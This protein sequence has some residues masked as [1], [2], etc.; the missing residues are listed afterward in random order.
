MVPFREYPNGLFLRKSFSIIKVTALEVLSEPLTLLVLLAALVLT[1]LAPAFHYHQ[2]GDPSRMARDAGFSALLMGGSVLAVFGT[3]RTFRRE[4]E[5]GTLEGALSHPISRTTFFLSKTAGIFLA[6]LIFA[7]LVFGTTS[8]IVEGAIIGG[9]LAKKTGMLARI[10]GPCLLGGVAVIILPLVLSAILNR[11]LH[12]RFVVSSL[13]LS[14]FFSLINFGGALWLSKGSIIRLFPV[15]ILVLL[16]TVIL[17]VG[18]AVF[19]IRLKANLAAS[20]AGI[21]FLVLIPAI[22]NYYLVDA[23][24]DGGV[25]PYSYVGLA[26]LVTLPAVIAFLLLGIHLITKQDI[27]WTR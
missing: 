20:C 6:Y 11:L 17:M 25:V 13:V 9:V 19:S 22:G 15:A 7:A 16:P 1:V 24:A 5:S 18:A 26:V 2:F 27:Q 23:L 10:F 12:V 21:V 3:I 4:M 14:L 8:V